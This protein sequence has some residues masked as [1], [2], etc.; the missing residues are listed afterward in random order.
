[1]PAEILSVKKDHRNS[2]H[3]VARMLFPKQSPYF[4]EETA[5]PKARSDM[6]IMRIVA[7]VRKEM[8]EP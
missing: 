6:F 2:Q 1:M 3:V 5:S 4:S 8:D 7:G